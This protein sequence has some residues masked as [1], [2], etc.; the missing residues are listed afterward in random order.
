MTSIVQARVD[1]DLKASAA[2]VLQ[3]MG[4]TLSDAVRILLT[5]ID[6]EKRLPLELVPNALTV[7]THRKVLRG[8]DVLEAKDADDLFRQLEA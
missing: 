2:A 3:E 6:R 7:E 8:E 5:R 1:A 4:L